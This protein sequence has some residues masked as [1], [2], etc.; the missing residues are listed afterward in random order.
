MIIFVGDG[1]GMSTIT[2]GRILKGQLK[3][4]RGEE[5]QL[6]FDGFPYIGLSKVYL[7]KSFNKQYNYYL[8]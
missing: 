3:G 7:F 8:L 2:A 1:M 4:R 6:S 5:E